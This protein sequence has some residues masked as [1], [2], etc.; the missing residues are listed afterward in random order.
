M[1]LFGMPNTYNCVY[2]WHVFLRHGNF[3]RF[4][5]VCDVPA[6]DMPVTQPMP[7]RDHKWWVGVAG[8]PAHGHGRGHSH[9]HGIFILS[10]K[11]KWKPKKASSAVPF[12]YFIMDA[13][14]WGTHAKDT[15]MHA[16]CTSMYV[17]VC[18]WIVMNAGTWHI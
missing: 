2:I 10:T 9:S 1:V 7:E 12:I 5:F 16:S 13:S 3:S 8:H 4:R 11:E 17:R 18:A 6:Y 15:R 14:L